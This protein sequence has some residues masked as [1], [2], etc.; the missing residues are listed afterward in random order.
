VLSI[1]QTLYR[2]T[3]DS[4]LLKSLIVASQRGKQVTAL[5]E[6]RARFDEAN[7]IRW[8]QQLE[9]AGVHVVYGL[10]NR[11]IH[12]KCTL[13]TRQEGERLIHYAHV[14][15]GNYNAKT[16]RSYTDLSLFTAKPEITHDIAQLFN[17]L[18]GFG[19]RPIFNHLLIAPFN[20][21]QNLNELIHRETENAKAGQPARIIAKLN[22]L[23]DRGTISSLYAASNAGV[24]IQLSIR[25]ICCLRPGIKGFS[26]NIEVRSILGR[27][28]EHARIIYFENKGKPL[29]FLGS[30]DW[31][32]RNFY[33]RIEAI[34]PILD[35][36]LKDRLI[37][38]ILQKEFSDNTTAWKLQPNGEYIL[39]KPARNRI[40]VS[41]QD[42]FLAQYCHKIPNQ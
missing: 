13:V 25:G 4:P 15:T 2:T 24:K 27:F 23:V 21:H 1:K 8:A 12:A 31:M 20:M 17:A 38:D 39:P 33:N 34:T 16:A 30:A 32:P 6:L 37:T 40:K 19:K 41:S 22:N 14:S 42:A 18:T 36:Q 28:L 35:V 29:V 3:G 11:K 5:V 10:I 9:E 7:N 26:E